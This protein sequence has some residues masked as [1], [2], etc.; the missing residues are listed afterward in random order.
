MKSVNLSNNQFKNAGLKE[1]I[2]CDWP[3][4]QFLRL[5]N[6]GITE[7]G[8]KI[9]AKNRWHHLKNIDISYN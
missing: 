3:Q 6:T 4:L 2:K 8:V 1:L 5:D 7:N 9:L